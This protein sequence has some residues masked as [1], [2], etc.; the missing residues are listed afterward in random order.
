MVENEPS[1]WLDY[2]DCYTTK[3]TC[4]AQSARRLRSYAAGKADHYMMK[5][6]RIQQLELNHCS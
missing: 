6:G 1:Q 5:K 3:W 4:C 2:L